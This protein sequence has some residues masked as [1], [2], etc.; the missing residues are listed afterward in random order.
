MT[1]NSPTE[2]PAPDRTTRDQGGRLVGVSWGA[3]PG[4]H[5]DHF[6]SWLVA[7][8]G[9]AGSLRAASM[10]ARLV[11]VESTSGV[12][13]VHV[14][15]WLV[16]EAAEV[17][18][19]RRGWHTTAAAR[20]RMDEAGIPWRLHVRMGEAAKEIVTLAE[21]LG[22]RGIAIG[23]HGLTATESIFLGSVSQKVLQLGKL[24][25]LIVR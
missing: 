11:A 8:D 17:E 5:P 4:R 3:D 10:V 9:S 21:Q 20:A 24:P 23:S 2:I 16:K 25:V 7:V 12:D 19:A 6:G 18:L 1:N 22:S 14:H 15:P 13:L